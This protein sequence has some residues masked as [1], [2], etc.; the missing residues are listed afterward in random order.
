MRSCVKPVDGV[1]TGGRWSPE[2]LSFIDKLAA[3]RAREAPSALRF[4]TFVAWQKRCGMLSFL[5]A[6]HSPGPLCLQRTT[7]WKALTATCLTWLIC[8]QL[9]SFVW[10]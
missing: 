10:F 7:S 2:A 3:T 6:A 8:F 4:S 9:S 5:A 1:E